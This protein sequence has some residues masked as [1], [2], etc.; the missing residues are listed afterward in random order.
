[1]DIVERLKE[2][3]ETV[4]QGRVVWAEALTL[5]SAAMQKGE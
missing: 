4:T 2:L 3:A 5:K 1:M